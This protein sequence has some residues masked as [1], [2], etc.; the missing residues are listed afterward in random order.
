LLQFGNW[1]GASI[2]SEHNE[3][4]VLNR[5]QLC[6]HSTLGTLGESATGQNLECYYW[7]N[8]KASEFLPDERTK[9]LLGTEGVQ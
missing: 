3:V 5:E 2:V 6:L 4:Q 9:A 1:H 7:W 8:A